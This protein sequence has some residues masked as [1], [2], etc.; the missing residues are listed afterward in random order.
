MTVV[1]ELISVHGSQVRAL[2]SLR[3]PQSAS[4]AQAEDVGLRVG[5][6]A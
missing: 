1:L 6:K 3:T 4:I 5:T 2:G